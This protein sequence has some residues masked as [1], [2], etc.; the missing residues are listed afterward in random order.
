[1][2]FSRFAQSAIALLLLVIGFAAPTHAQ[3][4]KPIRSGTWYEDRVATSVNGTASQN[5]TVTF[6]QTP[7][8]MF[9]NITNVACTFIVNSTSA[10][11]Q[12]LWDVNMIVGTT[13][14]ANDLGRFYPLRG[15]IAAP[16]SSGTGTKYYSIIRDGIFFKLGPGR[17]PSIT[18][19]APGTGN[20]N[21]FSTSVGC[22]I[23]GNLTD[24]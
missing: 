13:S 6:A 8:D 21:L 9:L 1:M 22:I 17:Y 15:N 5:M 20:S 19:L 18:I 24:S 10:G 16:E 23:V 4:N 14:G 12:T 3:G 11:N 2:L 7:G